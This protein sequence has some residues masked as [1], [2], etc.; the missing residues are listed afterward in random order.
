MLNKL[1]IPSFARLPR[2]KIL[3]EDSSHGMLPLQFNTLGVISCRTIYKTIDRVG[4]RKISL[5]RVSREFISLVSFIK[6]HQK[7]VNLKYIYI[8]IQSYEIKSWELLYLSY[9]TL[10]Y[11]DIFQVKEKKFFFLQILPL[12][13]SSRLFSQLCFYDIS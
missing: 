2:V 13:S 9:P 3:R 6:Y 11:R 12:I 4:R 1:Q 7:R 5:S 8:Y 10:F